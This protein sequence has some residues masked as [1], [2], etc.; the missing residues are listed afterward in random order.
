MAAEP[1]ADDPGPRADKARETAAKATKA[2]RS[3]LAARIAG[4]GEE[5]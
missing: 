1:A 5:P 3:R 2:A 4:R